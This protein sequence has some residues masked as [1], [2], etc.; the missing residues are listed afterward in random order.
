MNIKRLRKHTAFIRDFSARCRSEHIVS[1]ARSRGTYYN[2]FYVCSVLDF[3]FDGWIRIWNYLCHWWN[4]GG[5]LCFYLS[6]FCIGF[7]YPGK[8]DFGNHYDGSINIDRYVD[9]KN[10]KL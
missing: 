2:N 6:V 3:S 1:K 5:Q 7:Q 8:S 10:Q 4:A 9:H